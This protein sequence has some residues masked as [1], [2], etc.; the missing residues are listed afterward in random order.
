MYLNDIDLDRE[1]TFVD[2]ERLRIH[3]HEWVKDMVCDAYVY[4]VTLCISF[5]C[6]MAVLMKLM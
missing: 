1:L 5:W 6:M 4:P 3:H 2:R